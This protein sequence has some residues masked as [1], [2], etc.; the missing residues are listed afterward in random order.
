M[1]EWVDSRTGENVINE[2]GKVSDKVVNEF[3]HRYFKDF[4]PPK[5]KTLS[6]LEIVFSSIINYALQNARK[7][8]IKSTSGQAA[9]VVGYLSSR[10]DL[11]QIEVKFKKRGRN[12]K[13]AAKQPTTEQAQN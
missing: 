13:E 6:F 9:F 8:K 3:L 2:N 11:N 4:E 7:H 10:L 1:S 12:I 5:P